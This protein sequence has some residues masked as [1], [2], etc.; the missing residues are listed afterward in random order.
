LPVSNLGGVYGS[1]EDTANHSKV[2]I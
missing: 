1:Y 2:D